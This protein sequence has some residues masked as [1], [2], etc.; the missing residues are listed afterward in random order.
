MKVYVASM[1]NAIVLITLGL[2]GYCGSETPSPTALIPVFAGILLL[3]FV[4]GVK[5]GNR[6]IAHLAVLVT[7][8]LIIAFIKPL[9]GAIG[10]DDCSAIWRISAEMLSCAFSMVY[11]IRSFIAIRKAREA[12]GE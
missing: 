3:G 6:V 1:L 12:A 11:F 5:D 9:L 10:R 7:F 2:I 8:G 4:K